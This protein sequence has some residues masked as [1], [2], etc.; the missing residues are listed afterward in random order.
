MLTPSQKS[1]IYE[2]FR[3][4][5]LEYEAEHHPDRYQVEEFTE[6]DFENITDSDYLKVGGTA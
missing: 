5:E 2:I 1:T 4:A 3:E 6:L